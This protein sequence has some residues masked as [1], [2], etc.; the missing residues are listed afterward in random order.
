MGGMPGMGGMPDP[1]KMPRQQRE[2]FEKIQRAS[3]EER[4]RLMRQVDEMMS[5]FGAGGGDRGN[6]ARDEIGADAGME[7]VD[8]DGPQVISGGRQDDYDML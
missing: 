3:P 5:N 4:K 7:T 8:L 6:S 2:M 1:S